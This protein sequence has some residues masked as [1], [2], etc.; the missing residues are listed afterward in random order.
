MIRLFGR[1]K[2]IDVLTNIGG[3]KVKATLISDKRYGQ[4]QNPIVTRNCLNKIRYLYRRC[5][6]VEATVKY[7][8]GEKGMSEAMRQRPPLE[9]RVEECLSLGYDGG[10]E[11]DM[12]TWTSFLGLELHAP[13]FWRYWACEQ[14]NGEGR[15]I[16]AAT[17]LEQRLMEL[18]A[19]RRE[20]EAAK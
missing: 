16:T 2:I 10:T 9:S 12:I 15:L 17:V 13:L 5:N 4:I 8:L 3:F 7:L 18:E 1:I 20:L 6:S 14:T 11:E 19:E